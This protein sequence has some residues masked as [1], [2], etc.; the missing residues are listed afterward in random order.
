MNSLMIIIFHLTAKDTQFYVDAIVDHRG[1]FKWASANQYVSTTLSS[2]LHGHNT[3]GYVA[4]TASGSHASLFSHI[5]STA[6]RPLCEIKL[7]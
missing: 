2:T 1:H 5:C 7:H 3:C 4:L 6:F